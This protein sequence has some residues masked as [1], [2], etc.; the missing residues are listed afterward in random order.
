MRMTGIHF[1][2]IV[3][4]ALRVSMVHGECQHESRKRRVS[5]ASR[6]GG[7][8]DLMPTEHTKGHE[9]AVRI[10]FRLSVARLVSFC[11]YRLSHAV[12]RTV[13]GGR[14]TPDVSRFDLRNRD[15]HT[16]SRS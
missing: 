2:I 13:L 3:Y 12:R 14:Y 16:A 1:L 6:H 9:I 10:V 7:I 15:R 5:G 8:Q 11:V 4:G